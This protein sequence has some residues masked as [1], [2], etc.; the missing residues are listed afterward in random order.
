MRDAFW[1]RIWNYLEVVQKAPISPFVGSF[2]VNFVD[3]VSSF[4]G[5]ST[6][7]PTKFATKG[8]GL[9]GFGIGSMKP[10]RSLSIFAICLATL[11]VGSVARGQ[12][13]AFND[14]DSGP[15]TSPN[16]T[17]YNNLGAESGTGGFLKNILTG[18]NLPVTLTITTNA[19]TASSIKLDSSGPSPATGTPLANTFDGFVDFTTDVNLALD[20]VYNQSITYTFSGLDPTKKYV[21]QGGALRGNPA[22]TTRYSLFQLDGADSFASAHSA[23]CL[24]TVQVPSLLSN[25]VAIN[26]GDNSSPETGDMFDWEGIVPGS[27]GIISIF[28]RS[29]NGPLPGGGTAFRAGYALTAIKLTEAV[30]APVVIL[31]QPTNQLVNLGESAAF[32]V[33]ADGYPLSY[34]WFRDGSAVTG[35]TDAVLRL[36]AVDASDQGSRFSV[37]VSNQFNNLVSDEAVLAV[38]FPPFDVLPFSQVWRYEASGVD[39]GTA[40]K[41]VGFDDSN[42]ASG[43]GPLGFETAALP[44]PL[45]TL[46]ENN[47]QL[48]YYFRTTFEFTENLTDYDLSLVNMID[49]GAVFYLNGTEIL[50][51]RMPAG[52]IGFNTA[53]VP[54]AVRDAILETVKASLEAV[55]P[56]SNVLAVE[57]HQVNTSSSDLVF[58]T[59]LKA[60]FKDL[61]PIEI[62]NQPMDLSFAEGQTASLSVGASGFTPHYQW[63]KEGSAL[64]GATTASLEI[65]NVTMDDAGVYS[66][67]VSNLFGAVM[68]RETLLAVTIPVPLQAVV[69]PADP[70]V[71]VGTPVQFRVDVEADPPF[72]LQWKKDGQPLAGETSQVLDVSGLFLSDAGSY[73]VS[74][75]NFLGRIESDPAVLTMLEAPRGPAGSLDTNFNA[76]ADGIIQNMAALPDGRIYVAGPFGSVN[77]KVET[78][79]VRLN[80][81]GSVD[82]SFRANIGAYTLFA[83]TPLLNGS[84]LVGGQIFSVDGQPWDSLVRLHEDGR[85]DLSFDTRDSLSSSTVHEIAVQPDEKV[86]VGGLYLVSGV[87]LARLNVDGSLDE[88]F[89]PGTGADD[90]IRAMALQP[91]GRILI[92]GLF[93]H[94]DGQ[95]QPFLAR[96]WPDGSL[97]TQFLAGV[98]APDGAVY[99][100]AQDGDKILVGGSFT[101]I[102]QTAI[103]GVARLLMNDTGDLDD[104]FHPPGGVRGSTVLSIAQ[105][106]FGHLVIGGG[107]TNVNGVYIANLARLNPDGTLD[108]TFRPGLGPNSAVRATLALPSGDVMIGGFFSAYNSIPR[109]YIA[110][111]V[112]DSGP[113][114]KL[115]FQGSTE[116]LLSWPTNG[117]EGYQVQGRTLVDQGNWTDRPAPSNVVEGWN[118]LSIEATNQ[119]RFF[120]LHHPSDPLAK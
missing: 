9:L 114:L 41:E 12:W 67:S 84:V 79:V 96:L 33:T 36:P 70:T 25:Q 107:F 35:E 7:L 27:D 49:D 101:N 99:H 56:G 31:V 21:L 53:T 47:G 42:W 48:T 83:V 115:S 85:L 78:L 120:R 44:V 57:V 87:G 89:N 71:F 52:P 65:P 28:C 90:A 3:R 68:S 80:A 26:T 76:G 40:W 43:P 118:T 2:V 5:V 45:A 103:P 37:V 14:H 32:K 119:S 19:G 39:L 59:S 75:S 97:D 64:P 24:T 23:G 73:S 98:N 38:V 77:G 60:V 110:R 94:Y 17:L 111:I 113:Y 117:A 13:V 69:S 102:N 95:D 63:F 100:L 61:V 105:Q 30:E 15:G 6:K 86:I 11:A 54:P 51:V 106:R 91:D 112:G 66:V 4:I 116:A 55:Q 74:L 22:Y 81:D 72:S 18:T 16:A 108:P 88:T 29:Y 104:Q 1:E 58:G 50:R 82:E 20:N 92:G 46:L 8:T 34:Q 62:T 109:Q 10:P 93:R